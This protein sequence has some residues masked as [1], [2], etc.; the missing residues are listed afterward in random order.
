[1]QRG[2]ARLELR[3]GAGH[4]RQMS[5]G[6]DSS[7]TRHETEILP[8]DATGIARAAAALREGQLV[9]L[10]TETVYGL[11]ARFDDAEAV[12]SI[13]AAKARPRFD[14]LIVHLAPE[15]PLDGTLDRLIDRTRLSPAAASRLDALLSLW[16][17][18]LT[19]V[20][21]KAP[22]VLD[23]ITSGLDT[24]AIRVPRHAV[25]QELLRRSGPLAAPSAN[26]FGRISP[27]EA[28]HVLRELGGAL[29]FVRDGGP[30]EEG[31]ESTILGIEDEGTLRLLRPGAVS[32]DA[33][34]AALPGVPIL[35]GA[36]PSSASTSSAPS[37]P[38]A[39][40]MLAS[41]YAPRKPLTLWAGDSPPTSG[42]PARPL[43]L[44]AFDRAGAERGAALAPEVT[45][46][47]SATGDRREAARALF[48]A[49]RTLDGDPRVERI[50]AQ[51]CPDDAGLGLAIN[52]RL[53]RAAA[54]R[55]AP[56]AATP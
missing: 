16:P 31:V 25:A 20:L 40:G 21:P 11:A 6:D 15:A 32:L 2:G 37:A 17:A 33:L 55:H 35:R 49:L 29:P 36:T 27:T 44:L 46:T 8:A 13:F 42:E 19:L 43:G 28:E 56:R 50:V 54:D 1:M 24:V 51:P 26:R 10:P 5:E 14:P 52:D 30:C 45:I 22:S 4:P 34:H 23:E 18:P 38:Q 39:P 12:L 47:L 41:H 7:L 3:P 48:R 9:G 53:R